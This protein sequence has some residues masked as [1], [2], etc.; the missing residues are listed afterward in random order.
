MPFEDHTCDP[1]LEIP[2]MNMEEM[3][4]LTEKY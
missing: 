2:D 1:Q 4:E 3:L